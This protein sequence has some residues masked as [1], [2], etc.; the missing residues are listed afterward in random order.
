MKGFL[1][2]AGAKEEF[3]FPPRVVIV[4]NEVDRVRKGRVVVVVVVEVVVLLVVF[5][6]ALVPLTTL[7]LPV[8]WLESDMLSY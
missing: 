7:P 2:E 4:G 1:K 6:L 5:L 8:L 3:L